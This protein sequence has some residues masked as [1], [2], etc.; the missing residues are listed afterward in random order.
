MTHI[1]CIVVV[2]IL[3]VAP[4]IVFAGGGTEGDATMSDQIELRWRTRPD[5]QEEIDVYSSI[6]Q[7]ID[8]ELEGVTL[9]YEPGGS[10]TA[11]YQ[12]VLKTELDTRKNRSFR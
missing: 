3:L 7:Q 1:R 10:E 5:N 4:A 2:A 9:L 6:S 12:D 11:S 8:A